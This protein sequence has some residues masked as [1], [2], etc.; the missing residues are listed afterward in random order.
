[1]TP[2]QVKIMIKRIARLIRKTREDLGISSYRLCE[3]IGINKGQFHQYE[4]TGSGLG[5]KNFLIVLYYLS[6]KI[7]KKK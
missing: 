1:M 4:K 2:D 5:L 3:D 6:L 7:E